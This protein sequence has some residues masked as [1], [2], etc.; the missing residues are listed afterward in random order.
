MVIFTW[1]A[2][3]PE[4]M[5]VKIIIIICCVLAFLLLLVQWIY[6]P[7][8]WFDFDQVLH[9]EDFALFLLFFALGMAISWWLF[10]RKEKKQIK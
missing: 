2:G 5:L 8:H 9:H 3:H 10:T 4:K 6:F 1:A 7:G